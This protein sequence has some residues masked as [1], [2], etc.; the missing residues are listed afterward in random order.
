M[1]DSDRVAGDRTAGARRRRRGPR[2]T[3]LD[4]AFQRVLRPEGHDEEGSSMRIVIPSDLLD[5][6]GVT[7]PDLIDSVSAEW[8]E[9]EKVLANLRE[10]EGGD[11]QVL[12]DAVAVVSERELA[13]PEALARALAPLQSETT[14]LE[15]FYARAKYGLDR[16]SDYQ[17]SDLTP[18]QLLEVMR[19]QHNLE[20]VRNLAGFLRSL[21]RAAESF[22]ALA[23]PP[24]EIRRYLRQ[25]YSME[26]WQEMEDWVRW[27]ENKVAKVLRDRRPAP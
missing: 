19:K 23:V 10:V 16:L 27:L 1:S 24:A 6:V 21:N 5:T 7:L 11:D 26:D 4:Q 22:E 12:E 15:F 18:N 13:D 3:D 20:A 17:L 2:E 9:I 14:R 8:E 25:L